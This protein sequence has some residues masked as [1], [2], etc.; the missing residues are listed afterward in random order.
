MLS[1]LFQTLVDDASA[2]CGAAVAELRLL[3][4]LL[5]ERETVPAPK[6]KRPEAGAM[7]QVAVG[8]AVA[9]TRARREALAKRLRALTERGLFPQGAFKSVVLSRCEL[10]AAAVMELGTP[11]APFELW[12]AEVPLWVESRFAGS[13]RLLLEGAPPKSIV[14]TL[15][16]VGHEAAL[17]LTQE[18]ARRRALGLLDASRQMRALLASAAARLRRQTERTSVLRVLSEELRKAGFECA[19]ALT[20]DEQRLAVVHLSHRPG[21]TA[22]GLTALGLR[23]VSDLS[24]LAVDPARAPLLAALLSSPEP[25]V[26][27]RAHAT[28]RALFGRKATADIREQL[29]HIFDFHDVLA[30]PLR[31]GGDHP[32]GI[33]F[34]FGPRGQVPD[35]GA[36]ADLALQASWALER[37]ALRERA[38]QNA[39]MAEHEVEL[40]SRELREE[41]ARLI[42]IDRRKDNFLANV[43]H[44]LRS[45][46]VTVLGYTEMLLDERLGSLNDRQRQCLQVARSSGRRLKQFIE[47]LMDFSRFELTRA[48]PRL[49]AVDL[50]ELVSHAALGLTP[51]LLERRISLRQAIPRGCPRAKGDKDQLHQVLVNLLSNAERHCRDGGR[52]EVRATA[53]PDTLSISVKDNGSGIAPEH[54]PRIFERLYQVGDNVGRSREGLGLGLHIVKSLVESHEGQVSVESEPGKGATFTFTLPVWTE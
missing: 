44:E 37:C 15:K 34:A 32:L 16:G 14:R 49:G 51:R 27:V 13:L 53:T 20:Q 5:E 31:G 39:A 26:E 21:Q 10:E 28:L 47:E 36:L 41:V 38:F 3:P 43:S 46:L 18:R 7:E 48:A 24:N 45:P 54:L 8:G 30:A 11:L 40:R 23:R 6:D 2:I 52:I 1:R 50:K 19:V 42:E 25:V 9:G 4:G 33:L 29:I 22:R 35:L 17:Q 12:S